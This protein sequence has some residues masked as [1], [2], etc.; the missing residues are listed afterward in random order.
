MVVW[1]ARR[2]KDDLSTTSPSFLFCLLFCSEEGG[3]IFL[4]NIRLSPDYTALEPEDRI[5]TSHRREALKSDIAL[6]LFVP[7]QGEQSTE[8]FTGPVIS[9]IKDTVSDTKR[10]P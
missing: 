6:L 7:V 10:V 1:V 4:R 8:I 3:D 9:S 2:E 5:V